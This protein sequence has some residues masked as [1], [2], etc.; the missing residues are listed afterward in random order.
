MKIKNSN[1]LSH[2]IEAKRQAKLRLGRKFVILIVLYA[3][4]APIIFELFAVDEAN[5]RYLDAIGFYLLAVVCILIFG[6]NQ[7]ETLRDKFSLGMIVLSCF[8]AVID[9]RENNVIYRIM[10]IILGATISIYLR[11]NRKEI[12]T[13]SLKS[14]FV[15]LL[16]SI[17]AVVVLASISV[18]L[19]LPEIKSFQP[20]LLVVV[21]GEFWSQLA[22][23]SILEEVAFRG[24][25]FS[26]L[27]MI[28]WNEN[29]ALITQGI[30]FW[31][32][33]YVDIGTPK[34]F[35]V[36]VPLGTLFMT[37]IIKKYK[38]VYMS[39]TMHT[40]MNVFVALVAMW[41]SQYLK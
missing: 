11:I 7:L 1:T 23:I 24:L 4:L 8:L 38:M 33:H 36:I 6:L 28:G 17:G 16:W 32:W 34:V 14:F 21:A 10:F 40:L 25:I 9:P 13:P 39:A 37:L 30:I 20:S 19:G 2:T 31:G 26:L 41:I 12:K 15:G 5:Y 18:W 27:I 29:N 22:L 35:F 3:Y